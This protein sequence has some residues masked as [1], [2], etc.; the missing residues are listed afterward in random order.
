VM[1]ALLAIPVAIM[2]SV[3]VQSLF[4]KKNK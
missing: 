1:G 2:I 3:F 4:E